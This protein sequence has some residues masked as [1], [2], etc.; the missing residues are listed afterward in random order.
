M[1]DRPE[2]TRN[3]E[4]EDVEG[5]SHHAPKVGAPK[6]GREDEDVEG[7]SHHA[8]KVGAPKVGREDEDEDDVEAHSNFGA[9][10]VG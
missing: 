1:E 5:H 2:D 7:H 6:V 4:N 3:D 10:K 9:P 8:P